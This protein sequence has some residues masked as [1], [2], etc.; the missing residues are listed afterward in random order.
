[1]FAIASL[2]A[3]IAVSLVVTRVATVILVATGMSRQSARFQARSAFTGA[4][5]TT[6]ESEEVVSHPLRRRVVMMLMLLGNAGLVAAASTMILGFSR[7]GAGRDWMRV[8]ELVAGV[9]LLVFLSRNRHVDRRLTEWIRV[10]LRRFTDLGV[11]ERDS[12]VELPDDRVVAEVRVGEDDW[13]AGRSL[14]ELDLPGRGVRVLA[15][16]T[17]HDEYLD[18]LD[19]DS[20]VCPGDALVVYGPAEALDTVTRPPSAAPSAR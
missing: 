3:V 10:L 9:L 20:V 8:I 16:Q 1:M 19:G 5:F 4:G 14:R 18:D 15:R 6:T 12:L 13:A 7:G 2:L 11:P 17:E